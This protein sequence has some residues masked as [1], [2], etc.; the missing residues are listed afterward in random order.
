MAANN[1]ILSKLL[2]RLQ[3]KHTK[4]GAVTGAVTSVTCSGGRDLEIETTAF[5]RTAH[6]RQCSFSWRMLSEWLYAGLRERLQWESHALA[7]R[8][9]KLR[10]P[11]DA[12]W[13]PTGTRRVEPDRSGSGGPALPCR[14][15]EEGGTALPE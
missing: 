2:D 10:F 3:E 6:S 9:G 12:R 1:R 15:A 13:A 14:R 7:Q 11:S 5:A 4:D 8:P